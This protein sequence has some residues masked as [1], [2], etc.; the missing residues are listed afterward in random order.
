MSKKKT[1]TPI[2]FTKYYKHLQTKWSIKLL[3]IYKIR[4][5]HLSPPTVVQNYKINIFC[6]FECMYMK[7]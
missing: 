4:Y 6:M 2:W 5:S 3:N 1:Q 7:K